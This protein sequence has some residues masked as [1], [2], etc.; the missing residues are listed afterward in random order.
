MF[1]DLSKVNE[2]FGEMGYGD[3]LIVRFR[4]RGYVGNWNEG[5]GVIEAVYNGT[6]LNSTFMGD[7]LRTFHGN[8]VPVRVHKDPS[9]LSVYFNK[10]SVLQVYIP[11][12]A[13]QD[14]RLALGLAQAT[15]RT[16]TGSTICRC[17]AA[18]CST[19]GRWS[20]VC[21]STAALMSRG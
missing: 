12:W 10:A 6:L 13:P 9:G 21:R 18:T 14:G 15:G 17:R 8:A 2:A 19:W 3:G 20:L 4:T 7:S 5:H 11:D 16:I 1:G